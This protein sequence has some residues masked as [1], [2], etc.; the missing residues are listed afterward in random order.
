MPF[1][2]KRH[3]G[4]GRG[5]DE[6]SSCFHAGTWDMGHGTW[7]PSVGMTAGRSGLGSNR[8]T[9]YRKNKQDGLMYGDSLSI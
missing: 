8:Y 3:W 4:S 7:G 1:G 2:E 6:G 5:L 9:E